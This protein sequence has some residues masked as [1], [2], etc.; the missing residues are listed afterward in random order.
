MLG[1]LDRFMNRLGLLHNILSFFHFASSI[2]K[3]LEMNREG[4]LWKFLEQNLLVWRNLSKLEWGAVTGG[5]KQG[6]VLCCI[7]PM[8]D[9]LDR[10][11]RLVQSDAL[12]DQRGYERLRGHLLCDQRT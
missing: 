11:G 4:G 10:T 3:D 7:R 5:D 6:F 2:Q 1:Q 12:D 9:R 8:R